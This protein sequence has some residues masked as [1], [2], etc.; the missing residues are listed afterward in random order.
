MIGQGVD[1]KTARWPWGPFAAF[2]VFGL[3]WGCWGALLPSLQVQARVTDTQLGVALFALA[4]A[5]LPAMLSSGWIIDRLGA[6][7]L[8]P[9]TAMFAVAA[10]LPG[11]A[12][13]PIS[14][15]AAGAA[16]GAGSGTMDV[17][18]NAVV[19]GEEER[20]G[21]RLMHGAHAMFS[22][23]VVVAGASVG[24]ARSA[25]ADPL[26][27]L[28]AVAAVMATIALATARRAPGAQDGAVPRAVP[29]GGRLLLSRPLLV[30]G[31]LCALAYLVEGVMQSWSAIHL[32][33][34]FGAA[35]AIGGLGPALFAAAAASGRFGTQ[36]FA[37]RAA[38]R[39]L[40]VSAA[41]VGAIGTT[42]AAVAPS[43]PVAL[44]GVVL[45]GAG[46]SVAAPTI[47]SMTGW[48]VGHRERGRALASVTTVAYL[49]FLLGPPMVGAIAGAASLRWGLA[50]TAAV[51]VVL[52][53]LTRF[54]PRVPR[55]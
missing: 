35:P 6:R 4:G 5:A 42:V 17:T 20:T 31:G 9:A 29:H 51:A 18:M 47:F 19:A 55:G 22:L 37:A 16:V 45:A 32:E 13:S 48:L 21:R 14:L 41:L 2:G 53:V 46:I 49:G 54:A 50:T 27:V 40:L 1:A 23:G 30:L 34:T 44:V 11:L 3:F 15:A 39:V 25:G 36:R 28:A 52:A 24:V 38:D 10:V 26:P 33:D 7:A 12:H 8:A 43:A